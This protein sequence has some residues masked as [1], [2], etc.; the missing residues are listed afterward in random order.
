MAHLGEAVGDE[1]GAKPGVAQHIECSVGEGRCSRRRFTDR[2]G[3]T[4]SA[5]QTG[6]PALRPLIYNYPAKGYEQIADEFLIGDDMLVAPVITDKNERNVTL[7]PGTWYYQNKKWK[8]DKTYTIAVGLD[9]L[10]VF[11]KK[12]K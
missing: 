11:M 6:E 2:L 7:P 8:G 1:L 10:P 5:A 9:E 3:Q 4:R 12:N